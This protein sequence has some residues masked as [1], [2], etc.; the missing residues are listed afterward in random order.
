[1]GKADKLSLSGGLSGFPVFNQLQADMYNRCTLVYSNKEATSAGA[2]MSWMKQ[3]G[4]S[5]SYA[6]AFDLVR[7]ATVTTEYIP[8]PETV[9]LYERFKEESLALHNKLWA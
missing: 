7:G 8:N 1:M 4:R 5:K 2:W 6:Q 9:K 3:T